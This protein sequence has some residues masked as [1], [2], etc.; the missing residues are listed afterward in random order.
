[1]GRGDH[2]AERT[3]GKRAKRQEMPR[4]CLAKFMG[5]VFVLG[6]VPAFDT[7]DKKSKKPVFLKKLF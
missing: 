4:S 1:V 7:G 5:C 3:M 2:W 6:L